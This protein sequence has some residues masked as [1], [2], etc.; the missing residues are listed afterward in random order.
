MMDRPSEHA[1]Q[2]LKLDTPVQY[3]K[4]IG[5]RRAESLAAEGVR[6][7]GDLVDHPPFRYEDRTQFR[8]IRSLKE[9]EWVLIRATICSLD[10]MQTPHRRVTILE[11]LVKD[12]TGSVVLKFFNQPYLRN[13]YRE[14]LRIIVYGQELLSAR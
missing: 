10:G 12:E 9:D 2:I 5:P 8:P 11:M 3:V 13:V 6:T 7:V 1:R 14:G 4:G